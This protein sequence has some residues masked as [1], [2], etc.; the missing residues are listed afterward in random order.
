V[1][2]AA[3][4]PLA[5]PA[6]RVIGVDADADM[7]AA[8]AEDADA[9]GVAHHEIHGR[10]P[11][12]A[13]QAPRVDVAVCHSVFYGVSELVPFIREL[14]AH[15]RARVVVQLPERPPRSWLR[16][17]FQ[18]LHGLTLPEGPTADDAAAVVSEAG[19]DVHVERWDRPMRE[20]GSETTASNRCAGVCASGPPGT[21]RS[22]SCSSANPRRR[23]GA[24]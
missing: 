19:F 3:G 9:R 15:A 8:F 16:P 1:V 22:A 2:R 13:D 4:L 12:V 6:A 20:S 17:Y 23:R 10:W 5:P 24:P 11:A 21:P 7:L 14:T 18:A